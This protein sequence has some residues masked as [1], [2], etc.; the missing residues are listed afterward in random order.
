MKVFIS[1]TQQDKKH[2]EL[3]AHRLREEGHEVWY[4]GWKLRAGDN[5]VEKINE[6]LKETDALIVIVSRNSL[7]SKWVM[8]EFSALAFGELSGK[9]NRIIPVLV[10]KSTVPEYLARY[11]YVDLS[12]NLEFGLS[13]PAPDEYRRPTEN[14]HTRKL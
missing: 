13:S 5:L 12:E 7:R 11:V 4:D 6:G 3:I 2:A 10:D 9:T 1:Y 14:V 8:H